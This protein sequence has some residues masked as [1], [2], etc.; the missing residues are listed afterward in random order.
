MCKGCL[1]ADDVDVLMA[2]HDW[3]L[4]PTE[5][6]STVCNGNVLVDYLPQPEWAAREELLHEAFIAGWNAA[7]AEVAEAE[8]DANT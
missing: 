1:K 8:A 5:E 7:K 6:D 4:S 2:C 3:L